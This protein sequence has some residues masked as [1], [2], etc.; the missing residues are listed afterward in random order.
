MNK[1]KMR[2]AVNKIVS[3][4]LMLVGIAI[5]LMFGLCTIIYLTDKEFSAETGISFLI[6]C[7][8]A[9]SVGVWLISFCRE[10]FKLIKEFKKYF[11]VV[12]NSPDGYIPDIA[13]SLGISEGIVKEKLELMIGNKYFS[14]AYIDLKSNCFVM[15]NN[16][17][18]NSIAEQQIHMDMQA[19][20]SVKDS[21]HAEMIAVK[22]NSCGGITIIQKGK[23]GECDYCGSP[24]KSE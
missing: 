7:L 20:S 10:K 3:L 16:Q 1:S 5:V 6:I 9:V 13:A 12:S 8:I 17:K 4:I 18:T 15:R 23:F 19:Y 22:C 11:A 21:Q 2:I 14:D 24:I